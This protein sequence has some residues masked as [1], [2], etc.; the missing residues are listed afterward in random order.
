MSQRGCY[1][2]ALPIVDALLDAGHR[3]VA[4]TQAADRVDL[5]WEIEV[6]PDHFLPPPPA[7]PEA[8]GVPVDLQAALA[9]KILLAGWHASEVEHLV[10]HYGVELVL[11]D[12]FR[13]GAGF[14]AE[15]R[16]VP[17]IAY[18]HHYFDEAGTSEGMVEYYCQRFG[19]PTEAAEVFARWWPVLVET[20]RG[21]SPAMAGIDPCWW[22]LSSTATMVLGLSDFKLHTRPT[23]TFVHRVGPTV[24]QPP[25]AVLPESLA[26]L[27]RERPA[28]LV[29]MSTNPVGDEALVETARDLAVDLDVVLTAGG[30]SLPDAVR[31]VRA[32]GDLSHGLLMD[33]VQ[34]VVCSGGHGT[35]T[36][37]ACA[38]V[39]VVA[40]PRMGDQFLVS[41][42]VAKSGLGRR[43]AATETP[44]AVAAATRD[45]LRGDRSVAERM[46]R[47]ADPGSTVTEALS[48]IEAA[49]VIS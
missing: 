48:L 19:R 7:L 18:T 31:G 39:P 1:E 34:V 36:R 3:V 13:L 4:S 5:P 32:V 45:V 16:G 23:P 30:R 44:Q 49:V 6:I 14:G 29:A 38:G 33:K 22:N 28:V 8:S 25:G 10:G 46:G 20:L 47:V 26:D 27:G 43:V 40:V 35:V 42:A 9:G 37:A 15:R 17:W 12:G 11:A 21:P 24:W 41:E 2:P